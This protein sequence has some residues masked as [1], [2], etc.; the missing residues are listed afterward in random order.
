MEKGKVKK[1]R[2]LIKHLARNLSRDETEGMGRKKWLKDIYFIV[3]Q[4]IP[5]G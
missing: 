4:I 5:L 1:P 3:K 2:M